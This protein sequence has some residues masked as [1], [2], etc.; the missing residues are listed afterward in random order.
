MQKKFICLT[1]A[2]L[3]M[4]ACG[5]CETSNGNDSF[6]H[7]SIQYTYR[8]E[9]SKEPTCEEMGVKTYI[10]NEDSTLSY[11]EPIPALGHLYDVSALEF[12]W[13]GYESASVTTTC[14]RCGKE[15]TFAADIVSSIEKEP[16]CTEKGERVYTATVL[17]NGNTYRNVRKEELVAEHV[18]EKVEEESFSASYATD[19]KLVQK[20]LSC[21]DK[22]ETALPKQRD[23][24]E[25]YGQEENPFLISSM[26]DWNA[27]ALDASAN[28]FAGKYIKITEN[29]GSKENP[30]TS[31]ANNYEAMFAGTLLGNGKT[32]YV[33]LPVRLTSKKAKERTGLFAFASNASF[34]DITIEGVVGE[35][36]DG[37]SI[38]ASLLAD[39]RNSI[40]IDNCVNKANVYG[41][42]TV[43]G[44]VG[45]AC[46]GSSITI[47]NCRNEGAIYAIE[48]IAGG[49]VGNA[50]G[51][52]LKILSSVNSGTIAASKTSCDQFVG[53]IK[54]PTAVSIDEKCQKLGH[55]YFHSQRSFD[56]NGHYYTCLEEGCEAKLETKGHDFN[57]VEEVPSTCQE[58]G[59]KAHYTCSDCDA[60]FLKNGDVYS[61]VEDTS[62][63]L[64]PLSAHHYGEAYENDETSH[65]HLCEICGVESNHVAHVKDYEQV[66]EEHG[67]SCVECGYQISPPLSHTHQFDNLTSEVK[68]SYASEGH[69]AYATCPCGKI[70]TADTHEETTLDSLKLLS[71]KEDAAK[72]Y[73]TSEENPYLIAN[74]T[75][76]LAFKDAVDNGT[77]FEGMFVRMSEDIG[78]KEH[79]ITSSIGSMKDK[80]FKGTFDGDGHCVYLS[81]DSTSAYQGIFGYVDGGVIK[82]LVAK[83]SLRTKT[84][85][86][87]ANRAGAIVAYASATA[88]SS[89]KNYASIAV[90]DGLG[91]VGGLVGYAISKS[92]VLDCE[93]Y[94]SIACE[95]EKTKYVG[96]IVGNASTITIRNCVNGYLSLS[97]G[98]G[99]GTI[100]DV[101]QFAG[102]ILGGAQGQVTI[103]SC[104]NHMDI[105]SSISGSAGVSGIV[106]LVNTGSKNSLIANCSNYG[107]LS[108]LASVG[109]IVGRLAAK[110]TTSD[111][112]IITIRKC[113]SDAS[114]SKVGDTIASEEVGSVEN[115]D[116][117]K[118]IPGIL[119]GSTSGSSSL[120]RIVNE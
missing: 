42:D 50:E 47:A 38:A 77:S 112:Y 19:G 107:N 8:E 43:A 24:F 41:K 81:I 53:R 116:E 58:T 106:G 59:V 2:F 87:I 68:A 110:G 9:V 21:G 94:G 7:T 54:T 100:A 15:T 92:Q 103:D 56:E 11:T 27:F 89:C 1:L 3:T 79:P 80:P 14:L 30:I 35:D 88:I 65:W 26:E 76:Y 102:G 105:H 118:K 44:L 66:A 86:N 104:Q 108:G 61:L 36:M 60:L 40:S 5:G 16:T 119:V 13:E 57:F 52:S 99:Q 67:I 98:N 63:L 51:K 111:P 29:I 69:R 31:Y 49:L 62:E 12:V 20:C 18:Y 37:S 70:F 109:G 90:V 17:I 10:C 83:G 115:T 82:N 45:F 6:S 71:Q 39:G 48:N 113:Q 75:D 73:G 120:P 74:E 95:G 84:A 117:S 97:E 85:S 91:D 32:L 25:N 93:N 4:L 46:G 55:A 34:K 72:G 101:Y 22:K 114:L 23:D 28:S 33:N 64:V 78:S 96:G